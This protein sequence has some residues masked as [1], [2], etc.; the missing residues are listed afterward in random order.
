MALLLMQ[1]SLQA[2]ID[3]G[4]GAWH[5][6]KHHHGT[7]VASVLSPIVWSSVLSCRVQCVQRHDRAALHHCVRGAVLQHGCTP[8]HFALVIVPS[9]LAFHSWREPDMLVIAHGICKAFF[10]IAAAEP[11]MRAVIN[12]V[13][14]QAGSVLGVQVVHCISVS[15]AVVQ[16]SSAQ[17]QRYPVH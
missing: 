7:G 14:A 5:I 17:S 8:L 9:V 16:R 1:R 10:M 11:R 2:R 13:P 4:V 15:A 6:S 3:E 12:G